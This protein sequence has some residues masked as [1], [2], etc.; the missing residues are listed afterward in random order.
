MKEQTQETER[1][2]GTGSARKPAQKRRG[3]ETL[4]LFKITRPHL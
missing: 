2:Q 3:W 4:G 1:G